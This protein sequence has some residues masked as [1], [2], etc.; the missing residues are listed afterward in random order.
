MERPRALGTVALAPRRSTQAVAEFR[1]F[2]RVLGLRPEVEPA[3]ELAAGFLD[4]RPEAIA[5]VGPVVV[6]EPGQDVG[7]DLLPRRRPAA[8]DVAHYV[9]VGIELDEQVDVVRREA[10]QDESLGLHED[11]H[12]AIVAVSRPRCQRHVN[13]MA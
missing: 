6:Q 7:F 9:R 1:L 4:D 5:R 12:R 13:V 10:P 3:D 2:G 8:V 11:L